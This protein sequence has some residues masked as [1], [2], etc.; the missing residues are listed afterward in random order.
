MR[1]LIYCRK[2][3]EDKKRQI[4]S[5]PSQRAEIER[6][7][8][9]DA[10]IEVAG[11]LKEERTAKLPGRP[12]FNDMIRR[13]ERGDANGIVAWSPDRL[14]RNSIDGGRI[15]YLLDRGILKDLKFVTYNFENNPQGKF[16][17]AILFADSKLYVD[18]LS[19]NIRRGQN[20]K[21][22]NG[23]YPGYPPLGYRLDPETKHI[24]PDSEHFKVIQRLLRLAVTGSY[25]AAQ[26]LWKVNVEWGYR[27]P[28]KRKHGGGP[29]S[30]STLYRILGD[31]FCAGYF[32]WN[33]LFRQGKHQPMITLDEFNRLRKLRGRAGIQ[34][35]QRQS[36]P[37][38]GLMRCGACGLG[39]TA[40]NRVNRHGSHYVYYHCTK[41]KQAPR[42]TQPSIQAKELQRQLATRYVDRIS[43][44][45]CTQKSLLA[46]LA[47]ESTSSVANLLAAR[48][49]IEA[50]VRELAVQRSTLTDLRVRQVIGDEDYLSRCRAI[51]ADVASAKERLAEL[52]QSED[53][54]EPEELLLLLRN[55]AASWFEGGDDDTK[56]LI[57]S[58]VGSNFLLTDKKASCEAKK[59]F[60]FE[61]REPSI[62]Y[63]WRW[64]KDVR[65]LY[66]TRD[67]SLLAILDNIREIKARVEE[68]GYTEASPAS[69]VHERESNTDLESRT[70]GP[71]RR[72]RPFP[73][74]APLA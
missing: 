36:F 74:H 12:I 17:L 1:Y 69:E 27:T 5:I 72:Q 37:F 42:C 19:V 25:S 54:F 48:E 67:P 8:K 61:V 59:P 20:A 60:T 73:P 68:A 4:V 22:E 14:A 15:I 71:S 53:R 7:F 46:K 33:G 6:K 52:N 49:T 43:V 39:V 38:T 63:M 58:T 9:S 16:M 66:N 11:D 41:R 18:S 13:I 21:A 26:L 2:S 34:R 3:T 10:T 30:L 51:D 64:L 40:E 44:S 45:D 65:T 24:M 50:K 47:R 56:R 28:K 55:K 70:G 62:P 32:H 31:P 35:P 23:W 57:L 29:L